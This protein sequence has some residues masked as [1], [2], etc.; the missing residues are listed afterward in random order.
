MFNVSLRITNDEAEAEDVLQEAFVSAFQYLSTFNQ[1]AS[2]G[3]WLKRIVV[4]KAL[5]HVKRR[6]L[7]T[8][9][10]EDELDMVEEYEEVDFKY[11]VGQVKHAMEQ[12]PDGYRTVFSLYLI[13]GYDH[14]EIAEI[15]G[16]TESTSKSQFNR[17]KK[18]LIEILKQE[19]VYER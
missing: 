18:K 8:I 5:N 12:L 3:A 11:D 14:R 17:S 1:S 10:M 4:N 2:F 15:M 9:P 16:V 13:E 6:K 7:D 19:V